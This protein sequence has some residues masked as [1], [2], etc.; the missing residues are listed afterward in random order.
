LNG[1]A[2]PLHGRASQ[3]VVQFLKLMDKELNGKF[4]HDSVRQWV[5]KHLA[6]GKVVPGYGHAVLRKTD[7]RF[8]C[9]QDYSAKYIGEDKFIKLVGILYEVV[10]DVLLKEGKANNPWPNVDAHS[11]VIWNYFGLKEA[12]YYTIL[13]GVSRAFGVL[14]SLVWDR[15]LG[16][17]LE[18]PK[19]I[20]TDWIKQNCK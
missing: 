20:T 13:F 19:S 7:P 6:S 10:P 9:Q 2:G 15:I 5:E 18:R 16:F 3:D 1:L 14:S 12:E 11:G 8:T 17:P 4:T